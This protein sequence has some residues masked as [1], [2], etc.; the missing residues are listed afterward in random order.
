MKL[1]PKEK[2]YGKI[3]NKVGRTKQGSIQKEHTL[4]R[5]GGFET[6]G[7]T[8]LETFSTHSVLTTE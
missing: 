5:P 1:K 4:N 2:S 3:R 7:Q 8:V 6:V